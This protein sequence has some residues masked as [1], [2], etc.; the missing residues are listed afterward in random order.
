[1]SDGLISYLLVVDSSQKT[2]Q[3]WI[4]K[5]DLL[6]E[7]VNWQKILPDAAVLISRAEVRTVNTLLRDAMPNKRYLLVRTEMGA[8]QG[9]LAKSAWDFINKPQAVDDD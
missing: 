3:D 7:I 1:M 5:I 2:L 9:W 8:K 6:P 4:E